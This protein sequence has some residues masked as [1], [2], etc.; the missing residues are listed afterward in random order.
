MRPDLGNNLQKTS[1]SIQ[2]KIYAMYAFV[3]VIMATII[4]FTVK[5][6][7]SERTIN[8]AIKYQDEVV[9]HAADLVH[10]SLELG[11]IEEYLG[12]IGSYIGQLAN[13]SGGQAILLDGEDNI[14]ITRHFNKPSDH[15][16]TSEETM[17]LQVNIA[18]IISEGDYPI[19][20]GLDN[21]IGFKEKVMVKA[22]L[23]PD[24]KWKIVSIIPM[25]HLGKTA[26][27]IINRVIIIFM[28]SIAAGMLVV[29][30]FTNV[31]LINP[32][33][34]IIKALK[35][36]NT[37]GH[38]L[39]LE[40]FNHDEIGL[41]AYWFN[42]RTEELLKAKERAEIANQHKGEFLATMS[43]EIRTPINGIMGMTELLLETN[44]NKKQAIQAETVLHS[45][46]SLL[47]IINDI[48]D[49][50]KIESGKLTI[51]ERSIHITKIIEDTA[52]FLKV[53]AKEK[54]LEIIT[55]IDPAVPACVISDP[56]RIRQIIYNLLGNAIKF[57][58]KGYIVIS[59]DLEEQR[60]AN[61]ALLRISVRDTGIGISKDKQELIFER[62]L[63]ADAST[64][65]KYGGTGLGLSICKVLAEMMGGGIGVISEP[66]EGSEFFFTILAEQCDELEDYEAPDI[67]DIKDCKV[68]V[69][70]DIKD[71]VD[72]ISNVLGSVDIAYDATTSSHQA[73]DMI[74]SAEDAGGHYDIL[75]VDYLMPET[76]GNTL[77]EMLKKEGYL[78]N[79]T[80]I[81]ISTAGKI[82]SPE[83]F[84]AIGINAHLV[85]PFKRD[86]LLRIMALSHRAHKNK[87]PQH[88]VYTIN[89]LNQSEE[90]INDGILF[91]SP[92][93]LLCEDNPVNQMY[94]NEVLERLGCVVDIADNGKTGLET[95]VS[96][97][98]C[99]NLVFMDCLMPEMDG[100]E[101]T[102]E[103]K[104]KVEN[105]ECFAVPVVALTANAM[106]GDREKCLAAG[107]EDYLAK[108]LRK[109]DIIAMLVK[110]I[111]EFIVYSDNAAGGE[112][113]MSYIKSLE[114]AYRDG[115]INGLKYILKNFKAKHVG[116]STQE[117]VEI[118]ALIAQLDVMA[119][120]D[121]DEEFFKKIIKCI[122]DSESEDGGREE[123]CVDMEIFDATK[124]L[125]GDSIITMLKTYVSSSSKYVEDVNTGIADSDATLVAT[126]AHTL[127]SS[128]ASLGFAKVSSLAKEIEFLAKKDPNKVSSLE[129]L[130]TKLQQAY[131][132]VVDWC[133]SYMNG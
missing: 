59:L 91:K 8:D 73:H 45:A 11:E 20:R 14:I 71:N 5:S 106:K 100:Y 83:S 128:S 132:E 35:R 81:L 30:V 102:R 74:K 108:P 38:N 111:P 129:G 33:K 75:I 114:N 119:P 27:S 46:E 90:D 98:G 68:L 9:A 47:E 77:I 32:I 126:A 57:T 88:H 51:E 79:T 103:F 96:N 65:R 12:K 125:M 117:L 94:A 7:V 121:L 25:N 112:K 49:F 131:Q 118:D 56:V 87:R 34:R 21:F 85:K 31:V 116:L 53:K 10:H 40:T 61:H 6:M 18:K 16:L 72:M 89:D 86:N 95:L 110:W 99:Y 28:V 69:V 80:L 130:G 13:N 15:L 105:G 39:L 55:K 22:N 3:V 23:V 113:E 84:A 19:T 60:D 92:R 78:K 50:S 54:G 124:E 133:N 76:N 42:R 62:F 123:V 1:G 36:S 82:R 26:T 48:L 67:S 17:Q 58:N 64:T 107:M 4:I 104:N 66:N 120:I 29:F 41:I 52:E 2:A 122:S 70:D 24:S 127:K 101:A 97:N 109:K 37:N 63:Q 115:D 93:I 44:L 43:H